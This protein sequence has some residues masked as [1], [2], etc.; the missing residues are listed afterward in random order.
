MR[1]KL[2]RLPEWIRQQQN[3][4]D[5]LASQS[6]NDLIVRA[7]QTSAGISRG[8][9]LV[10]GKVPVKDGILANSLVSS[11]YG[12]SS[13]TAGGGQ[14]GAVVGTMRAGDR[15]SFRWTAAHAHLKHYGGEGQPGWYWVDEALNNWQG[16]VDAVVARIKTQVGA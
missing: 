11:L 2:S 12:T 1:F 13:M 6:A 15:V 16:T 9:D 10:V 4:L 7:S 14:F 3:L 5:A 8:G